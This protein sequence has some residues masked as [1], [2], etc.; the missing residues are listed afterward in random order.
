MNVRR[1]SMQRSKGEVLPKTT[2]LAAHVVS[3]RTN[4]YLERFDRP[5]SVLCRSVVRARPRCH[6]RSETPGTHP[7]SRCLPAWAKPYPAKI[8]LLPLTT[9]YLVRSIKVSTA[10][11]TKVFGLRRQ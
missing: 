8:P 4:A 11:I 1:L 2:Q 3:D 6:R 9:R 5:A 10:C 7:P